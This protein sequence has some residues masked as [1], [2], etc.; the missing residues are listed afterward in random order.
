[1]LLKSKQGECIHILLVK[2]FSLVA[3]TLKIKQDNNRPQI[4]TLTEKSTER[5]NK[6][7]EKETEQ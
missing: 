6:Y 4:Y 1:M 2:E 3:N 5:L 7:I